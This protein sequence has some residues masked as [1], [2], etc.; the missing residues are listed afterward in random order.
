MKLAPFVTCANRYKGI[1][2]GGININKRQPLFIL[3]NLFDYYK[4]H[5][6]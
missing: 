2:V 1:Q 4:Y 6:L 5:Y 3:D